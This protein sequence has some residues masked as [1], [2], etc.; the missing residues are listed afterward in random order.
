[1]LYY[2]LRKRIGEE[3]ALCVANTF[4]KILLIFG[5]EQVR[6]RT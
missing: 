5:R 6:S 3:R 2:W 1:M 4:E